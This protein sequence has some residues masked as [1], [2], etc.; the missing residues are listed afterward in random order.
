VT[1]A[2]DAGF[3]SIQVMTSGLR[4][5]DP[6]GANR[7]AEL[8]ITSIA[9]PIYGSTADLHDGVCGTRSHSRLLKAIDNALDTGIEVHLHTLAL[10][11]TLHDLPALARLCRDRWDLHVSI[12]PARPKE[13]V[14][15]YAAET[16][17]FSALEAALTGVPDED[18]ALVGFPDCVCPQRSRVGALV[19]E[20]YF[21]GQR[22]HFAEICTQC[23]RQ[24][25]CPG[26]VHAHLELRGSDGLR[27][28]Q[29]TRP[30]AQ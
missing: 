27:I 25:R 1:G 17:S 10:Q 28:W 14:Y 22:R 6:E 19:I 26:V 12:G 4:L 7:W 13:G 29:P 3:S 15:N 9:L 20:L 2:V 30:Q 11:R 8:G 23:V 5:T 21:R 18:L 24:P 16:P